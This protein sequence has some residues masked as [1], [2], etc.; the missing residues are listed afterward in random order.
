MPVV[1]LIAAMTLS[2]P[3]PAARAGAA[4]V[5]AR[6]RAVNGSLQSYTARLHFYI[7]LHSFITLPIRINGTLY[8]KRPDK[9]LLVFESVPKQAQAFKHFYATRGT[10]ET[11]PKSY[12]IELLDFARPGTRVLRMF[13]KEKGSLDH[14]LITVDSRTYTEIHEDWLYHDG[15]SIRVDTKNDTVGGFLLPVHQ[16]GDFDFPSYKAHVSADFEAYTLNP[17]IPD[18]IFK[19]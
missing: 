7:K 8:S 11:W 15:S 4:D 19:E 13:P 16:E 18:S 10:P 1:A 2:S 14:A 12:R 5:L 9:S 17:A 6:M 3:A